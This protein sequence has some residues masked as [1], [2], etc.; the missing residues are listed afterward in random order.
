MIL[1]PEIYPLIPDD[2]LQK[3]HCSNTVNLQLEV[4]L[5]RHSYTQPSHLST[6]A[7]FPDTQLDT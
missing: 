5:Q 2:I 6:G 3:S 4:L 1:I 7:G